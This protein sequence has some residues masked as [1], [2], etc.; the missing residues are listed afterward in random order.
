[1]CFSGE[2]LKFNLATK[3]GKDDVQ[4]GAFKWLCEQE[5]ALHDER[6]GEAKLSDKQKQGLE[7]GSRS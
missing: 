4:L 3:L 6:Y 7:I 5:L 2:A 1:M